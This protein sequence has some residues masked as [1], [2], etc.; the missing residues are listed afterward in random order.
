MSLRT[1]LYTGALPLT[2]RRV[3]WILGH[4]G[5]CPLWLEYI[6][7]R[8]DW[9]R[10]PRYETSHPVHRAGQLISPQCGWLSTAAQ[11]TSITGDS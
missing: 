11:L 5:R 4:G 6:S 3:C 2:D 8:R 10:P 7:Q 9:N 1:Q